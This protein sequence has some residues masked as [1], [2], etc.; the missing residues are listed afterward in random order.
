M[1]RSG[2]F[3]GWCCR[4]MGCLLDGTRVGSLGVLW[5]EVC[6]WWQSRPTLRGIDL[7]QPC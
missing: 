5:R 2:L 3:S 4:H 7:L 1:G 6:C